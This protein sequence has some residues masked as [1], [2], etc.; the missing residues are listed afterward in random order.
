ML[1]QLRKEAS[2][3]RLQAERTLAQ[4]NKVAPDAATSIGNNII[5][6]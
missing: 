6:K 5:I 3:Y 1:R 2:T 4:L